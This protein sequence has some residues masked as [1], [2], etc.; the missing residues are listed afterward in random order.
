MSISEWI[1]RVL[2]VC[3]A[4][5]G[6]LLILSIVVPAI[7]IGGPFPWWGDFLMGLLLV[8]IGVVLVRGGHV[9]A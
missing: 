6:V 7:G 9:T 3:L 8:A 2:G 1:I 5:V 4:I